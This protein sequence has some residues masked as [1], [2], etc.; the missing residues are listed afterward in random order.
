M[1]APKVYWQYSSRRILTLEYIEGVPLNNVRQMDAWKVDR[2][3]L[4]R[5][6]LRAF[7]QQS[8]TL[9]FFHADPHAS[10]G[11]CTPNGSLVMLDFGMVKRLPDNIRRGLTM[12]WMG[13]FFRNPRMYTDGVIEKGAIDEADRAIV[14]ETEIGRAHV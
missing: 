2:V 11:L 6:Y 3:E 10:N 4:A 7:F 5:T 14:E 8:L 13:A 12:E 9:G 1:R